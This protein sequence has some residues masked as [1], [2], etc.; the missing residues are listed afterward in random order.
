VRGRCKAIVKRELSPSE[1]HW[2][3]DRWWAKDEYTRLYEG[4][5]TLQEVDSKIDRVKEI[6][7]EEWGKAT[8]L[9]P[10][11]WWLWM[12]GT[13]ALD[14][15]LGLGANLEEV[16]GCIGL[17]EVI[18]GIRNPSDFESARFELALGAIL[19]E[20][21][22]NIIF[23]PSL[24]NGKEA[25]LSACK[26]DQQVFLEL[27][28]L[29]QSQGQ[30]AAS[31]FSSQIMMAI[32]DLTSPPD[33]PLLNYHFEVT[34][35][36]ELLNSLGAGPEID[37][38]IING[39]VE[40]IKKETQAR[41]QRGELEFEIPRVG[42]FVFDRESG[43]KNS[44]VASSYG[45]AWSELKRILQSHVRDAVNQLHPKAPGIIVVQ[46]EGELDEPLTE[47]IV[48]SLLSSLGSKA[49]HVSAS[50]F[51]PVTYSLPTRWAMFNAFSVIN[52]KAVYPPEN[53][54]AFRDLSDVLL[55]HKV[56]TPGS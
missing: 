27:K 1:L 44:G 6:F 51:L 43:T 11:H 56:V 12:Q 42:T 7:S 24:P 34:L 37:A 53:V 54:Q 25:D 46:S 20:C 41:V 36:P 22:H 48:S 32:N 40:K 13:M 4:R 55:K 52:P 49:Q 30:M 21:G 8:G 29:R 47:L 15:L 19:A 45:G 17:R 50:L 23:R 14:F 38:H 33:G 39:A 3:G 26:D 28:K 16:S 18:E 10:V 31:E 2:W 9:H 35:Y 5:T